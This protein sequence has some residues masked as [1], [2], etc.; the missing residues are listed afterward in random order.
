MY[1]QAPLAFNY[2]ANI[3][4]ADNKPLTN[5]DLGLR[6]AIIS[7]SNQQVEFLEENRT[8]TDFSGM[9]IINVGQGNVIE[10]CIADIAWGMGRYALTIEVDLEGGNNYEPL[11]SEEIYEVPYAY[12]SETA[13]EVLLPGLIGQR[14]KDGIPGAPGLRGLEGNRGPRGRTAGEGPRGENG[15]RGPTGPIGPQGPAGASG[16]PPGDPGPQGPKG[17]PG[18]NIGPR[19]P[20]GPTGDAGL[21]GLDGPIGI[22]GPPGLSGP[23]GIQGPPG[24]AS[25]IKGPQGPPGPRGEDRFCIGPQGAPGRLGIVCYACDTPGGDPSDKDTNH[26]GI[27][28]IRDCQGPQGPQGQEGPQGKRGEQ[29]TSAAFSQTATVPSPTMMTI[30]LDDGTN[31]ADDRPGFRYWDGNEWKD[32]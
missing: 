22:Q 31:R 10:G 6:I 28:D 23:Q 18:Q 30:Y 9:F 12:Y 20:R 7:L 32:L 3:V 5:T 27:F 17:D 24:T 2:Q 1:G 4:G 19:G 21:M 8:T 15:D 26:D 25:N 16:G 14:G 13:T 11:F 29:G